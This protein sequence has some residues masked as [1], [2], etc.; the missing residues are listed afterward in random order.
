MCEDVDDQKKQ[1]K[2]TWCLPQRIQMSVKEWRFPLCVYRFPDETDEVKLVEIVFMIVIYC[3][4]FMQ[5]MYERVCEVFG[6]D[7][8]SICCKPHLNGDYSPKKACTGSEA[9]ST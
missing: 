7:V 6:I 1:L 2:G 9:R 8:T 4:E 5:D 3:F